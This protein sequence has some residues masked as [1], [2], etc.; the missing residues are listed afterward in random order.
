MAVLCAVHAVKNTIAERHAAVGS[1]LHGYAHPW[2][3]TSSNTHLP[4]IIARQFYKKNLVPN[5]G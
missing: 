2:P 3:N 1:K 4:V 5:N